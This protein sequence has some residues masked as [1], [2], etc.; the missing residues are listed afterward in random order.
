MKRPLRNGL[1]LVF[2]LALCAASF[3]AIDPNLEITSYTMSENPAAPGHTVTLTLH[4]IDTEWATCADLI[5]LQIIGSYPLSVQGMDTKYLDTICYGDDVNGT[6]S[7]D[8]PVDSLAQEGTYPITVVTNYQWQFDKF[9]NTNTFNIVVLGTPS[10]T[11]SVTGSN[12]VDVYPGDDAAVTVTF[13]NIGNGRVE[14]AQAAMTAQDGVEVKWAGSQQELGEILP[15]GSTS[16]V[17]NV[18]ALKNTTPGDY[19]LTLNVDYEGE[20][21]ASGSQTFTFDLPVKKQADFL[22][23]VVSGTVVNPG[24][25]E[26]VTVQVTNTGS[27]EAKDVQVRIQPIYPFSTDGTVRYV[28]SLMP[29]QTVNLTYLVVV[30]K[31][32]TA[33]EQLSGLMFNYKDPQGTAFTD[34]EDFTLTV[35][36]ETLLD[37]AM[38]YWYLV[39]IVVLIIVFMVL[40]RIFKFVASALKEGDK[41]EPKGFN[42]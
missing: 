32:A 27:E 33:G 10:L 31:D 35:K 25:N 29:G 12:P 13:Q 37:Q 3:A 20:N 26:Q 41:P 28:E 34:T 4:I 8:I 40:S 11:A 14:S 24:K 18:E 23:R 19:Q 21:N 15:H 7:F 9:S 17:F 42:H 16:A 6:V 2:L 38:D 39:V 30:D 1:V 36:T 22:P 5:N